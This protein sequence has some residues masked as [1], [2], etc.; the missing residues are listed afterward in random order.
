MTEP[1]YEEVP[2]EGRAVPASAPAALALTARA[3]GGPRPALE[4]ARVL[5][6]GC[7]DGANLIPLA[8]HHPDW[9][10]L[11]VDTSERAIAAARAGAL[12]LGLGNVR[13]ERADVAELE[14]EGSTTS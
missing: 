12:A 3:H 8:F 11:G 13:F 2:Y 4:V 1:S 9:S 7:G 6:L 10:L 5:E 14:L